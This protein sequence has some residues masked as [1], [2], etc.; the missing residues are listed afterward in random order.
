[1]VKNGDS[2]IVK[3]DYDNIKRKENN[4]NMNNK[5]IKQNSF[6]YK[7]QKQDVNPDWLQAYLLE[8]ES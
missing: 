8:V 2:P 7:N 5:V 6:S 4:I 3:N 1:M